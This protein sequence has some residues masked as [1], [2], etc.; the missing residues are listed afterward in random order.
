MDAPAAPGYATG[1]L[2]DVLPDLCAALGVPAGPGE[3]GRLG[4]SAARRGVVVLVDGLGAA[5]LARRLGHAPWL[6]AQ[7]S[8]T[9][10]LPAGFPATTATSMGTFGTGLPSGTHG[11]L[12]YEV[13]VPGED[14]VFNELSWED[15]PVPEQWQP[16]RTW[17]ERAET[18]GLEVARIGAAYFDGSGLTRAALRGGG[19]VAAER[20]ADRVD[21]ALRAVRSAPRSLVYLYWGEVDKLGHVHGPESFEWTEELESVDR[22]L[23][24]LAAGLPAD[25]S[26]TVTADHGMVRCPHATRVDLA[27][28]PGLREGVRHLGGEPRATYVYCR[29]GAAADVAAAWSA[30]LGERA[31]VR[32][33]E[34]AVA[35]GWF[36]PVLPGHLPRIGD[37]VVAARGDLAVMDSARMRPQLLAL[38]GMHGGLEAEELDVPLVHV[39]ARVA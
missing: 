27:D 17:F 31:W 16:R 28:E 22:E 2:A 3:S 24:R 26:L 7:A 1:S 32:T 21:L 14:R 13:L 33:R 9:R 34:E 30:R 20:L 39:P 12:G 15:G 19:F 38:V 25:A 11:M 8:R 6:R 23:A 4:L 29:P 5:Q 37:V 18:E 36:G 10:T 35:E